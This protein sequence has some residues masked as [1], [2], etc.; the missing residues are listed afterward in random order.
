MGRDP[1][2][3][4][5][6]PTTLRA[7]R[8]LAYEPCLFFF[9]ATSASVPTEPSLLAAAG[10]DRIARFFFFT[11]IIGAAAAAVE[12]EEEEEEDELATDEDE[13]EEEEEDA[14][15]PTVVTPAGGAADED[16]EDA[17]KPMV[18]TPP[19]E[20]ACA[21]SPVGSAS[22]TMSATRPPP[23]ASNAAMVSFNSSTIS[24]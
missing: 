19:S 21:A 8:F 9:A 18:V 17:P 22:F 2:E 14:P 7:W 4:W 10:V 13:E 24:W 12:E 1:L 5:L 20:P 6:L 11:T 15:N 23:L 16:D 3:E